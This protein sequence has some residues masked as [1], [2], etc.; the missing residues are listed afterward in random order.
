M[1]STFS[2][3]FLSFMFHICN[4]LWILQWTKSGK[5][6]RI[7]LRDGAESKTRCVLITVGRNI[8]SV[9]LQFF[10]PNLRFIA[11]ASI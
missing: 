6:R 10:A 5:K 3:V 8:Y 2:A 7:Y 9:R 4:S 1:C 11:S